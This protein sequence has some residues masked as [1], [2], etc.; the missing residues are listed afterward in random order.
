MNRA[1]D[2]EPTARSWLQPRCVILDRRW[3][4]LGPRMW[5]RKDWDP[6]SLGSKAGGRS[7]VFFSF[8]YFQHKGL[9]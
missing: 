1:L 9:E 6:L 3:T 2:E 5:E 7:Q 8:F 4:S